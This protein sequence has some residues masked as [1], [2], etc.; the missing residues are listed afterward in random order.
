MKVKIVGAKTSDSPLYEG[1][2]RWCADKL[3]TKAGRTGLCVNLTCTDTIHREQKWAKVCYTDGGEKAPK[4]YKM[5]IT[6]TGVAL[7]YRLRCIAHEMVHVGQWANGVRSRDNHADL[8]CRWMVGGKSILYNLDGME[9]EDMPW[10]IEA[11]GREKGL[12][13]QFARAN[14]LLSEPWFVDTF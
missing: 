14:G 4:D 3:I 1:L 6:Q 2:I 9:Y 11:H 10:E 12:V 13:T 7:I 8:T 5:T